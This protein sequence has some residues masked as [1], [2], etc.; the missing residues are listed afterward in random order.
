MHLSQEEW[1]YVIEGEVRFP[2]RRS[3]SAARSL[4]D[5]S[6]PRAAALTALGASDEY[7]DYLG[8]E[9]PSAVKASYGAN[10]TRLAAFKKKYDPSNFFCF[11]QNIVPAA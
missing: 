4:V 8:D 1:F 7:V 11:N 9:G 6:S 10:Y 3:S 5:R 2:G